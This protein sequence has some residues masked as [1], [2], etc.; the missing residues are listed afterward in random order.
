MTI[1]KKLN[2]PL[3]AIFATLLLDKMGENLIYPLL[4]FILKSYNP[5]GLTLG[6]LAA[7]ATFFS[8]LAGPVIGSL[9][10][11]YGRRPI[12]IGC[13]GVNVIALLMFGVAATL[14]L[15]FLSRAIGGI[16]TATTGTAQAFI[17]DI[18]TPSNQ[19]RNQGISGAAFGLGA[20]IGPALGGGLVGYGATVPIFVAAILSG[21]NFIQV[22]A[23]IKESLP[24]ENRKPFLLKH[25]NI[26]LPIV[27][28]L[29]NPHT[30]RAATAFGCFNLAFSAFA[31]LLVLN[32]KDSLGWNAAQ[33]SGI[34]VI[35]GITLTYIQV[36][37]LGG[38]VERKG[39]AIVNRDGLLLVALGLGILPLAP[40]WPMA[41][42]TVVVSAG[43]LLAI[44]SGL[45]IPTARAMV[46]AG[47][48]ANEQGVSFGSLMALSGMASALGPVLGGLIYDQ[49]TAAAFLLQAAICLG[50]A[51][52]LG[53]K[54]RLISHASSDEMQ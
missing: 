18:S 23:L 12:L 36:G 38:L 53:A 48:Q 42:A 21:L 44:G 32:L 54:P 10:D 17:A 34:F 41:S 28:L 35:V 13:I 52:I 49:S 1:S 6:L 47:M 16:A 46:S 19:A 4:P 15:I 26:I 33:S 24:K 14:P 9:S 8:V 51:Y 45:T 3:T 7:T 25:F 20:I 30:Q 37:V 29:K 27:G 39:E 40:L 43:I 22:L 31:S 5:N 11:T 2:H 50:G